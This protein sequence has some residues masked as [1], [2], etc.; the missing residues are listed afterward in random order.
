MTADFAC[1]RELFSVEFLEIIKKQINFRG[2]AEQEQAKHKL[3]FE[4]FVQLQ[5]LQIHIDLLN[6]IDCK[7]FF[8]TEEFLKFQQK[9]NRLSLSLTQQAF[10]CG[11]SFRPSCLD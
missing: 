7:A 8:D 6:V 3:S 11:K 2:L 4:L 10:K 9:C 1:D 5:S